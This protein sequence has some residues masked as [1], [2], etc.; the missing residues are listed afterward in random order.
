[1]HYLGRQNGKPQFE[2]H[3]RTI[4]Y[5]QRKLNQIHTDVNQQIVSQVGQLVNDDLEKGTIRHYFTI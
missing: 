4:E 2:Y 1:M 5:I 3:Q